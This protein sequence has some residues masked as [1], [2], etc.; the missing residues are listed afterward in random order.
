MATG[1]TYRKGGEWV[2][3]LVPPEPRL[4]ET[5]DYI[6]RR[7]NWTAVCSGLAKTSTDGV[8]GLLELGERYL[9]EGRTSWRD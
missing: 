1:D 9:R 8:I 6:V 3:E 5:D 7:D 2:T 4:T